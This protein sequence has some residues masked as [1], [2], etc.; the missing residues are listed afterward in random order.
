MKEKLTL[1]FEAVRNLTNR[2]V[3]ILRAE[4]S[5]MK[6]GSEKSEI[7]LAEKMI[8]T[9]T[10]IWPGDW[11]VL[12]HTDEIFRGEI[13]RMPELKLDP[14]SAWKEWRDIGDAPYKREED[15]KYY[16]EMILEGDKLIKKEDRK[17]NPLNLAKGEDKY[18]T[19]T[20][21]SIYIDEQFLNKGLGEPKVIR[22]SKLSIDWESTSVRM[23][24]NP[25][26]TSTF[27]FV[28]CLFN[29]AYTKGTC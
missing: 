22:L 25:T 2:T 26:F 7:A 29:V 10:D 21:A 18:L 24:K 14:Q 19:G 5:L 28:I 13:Q 8:L 4:G 16:L 20:L 17:I 3:E 23:N 9:F 15:G 27:K 6:L 12:T 11:Y 1:F